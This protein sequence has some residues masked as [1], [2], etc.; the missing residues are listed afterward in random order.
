MWL[1]CRCGRLRTLVLVLADSEGYWDSSRPGRLR[2][3]GLIAQLAALASGA[4]ALRALQVVLPL[5]A[6]HRGLGPLWRALESLPN[7]AS[8]ALG[9]AFPKK[10][11]TSSVGQHIV[12]VLDAVRVRLAGMC[13]CRQHE[14]AHTDFCKCR[15]CGTLAGVP[16]A[17]ASQQGTCAHAPG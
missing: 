6:A 13:P 5:D 3:D 16:V 2:T 8:L 4:P 9:Y 14:Q 10:E 15:A 1:A 11:P 12:R 7:L 17:L